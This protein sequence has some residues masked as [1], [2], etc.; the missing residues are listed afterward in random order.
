MWTNVFQKTGP[1]PKAVE[2]L[3]LALRAGTP[4]KLPPS[5]PGDS[6]SG[7][8]LKITSTVTNEHLD[9]RPPKRIRVEP[10]VKSYHEERYSELVE[11][12]SAVIHAGG[13]YVDENLVP[14]VM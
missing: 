10:T 9:V 2:D 6:E 13:G 14:E 12:I 7:F 11:Q 4:L 1:F 8:N 5:D 3:Q